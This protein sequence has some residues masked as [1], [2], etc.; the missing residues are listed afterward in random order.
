MVVQFAPKNP[1]KP[2][3]PKNLPDWLPLDCIECDPTSIL[4]NFWENLVL[5]KVES[6]GTATDRIQSG[7]GL[8]KTYESLTHEGTI[9]AI[10]EDEL[11]NDQFILTAGHVIPDS[12]SIM[13]AKSAIEEISIELQVPNWASRRDGRPIDRQQFPVSAEDEVHGF[14]SPNA[15]DADKI[16]AIMQSV[17]C[18]HLTNTLWAQRSRILS[19]SERPSAL[20]T[21]VNTSDMYAL[22]ESKRTDTRLVTQRGAW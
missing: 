1:A 10:V 7:S 21:L 14:L 15:E 20:T 3:S 13:V 19:H 17:D 22:Y 5:E 9:G 16:D 11:T 2:P 12:E 18:Y 6:D 8:F 4:A